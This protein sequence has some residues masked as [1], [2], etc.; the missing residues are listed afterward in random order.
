MLFGYCMLQVFTQPV[1]QLMEARICKVIGRVSVPVMGRVLLRVV[2]VLLLTFVAILVSQF[3]SCKDSQDHNQ[4]PFAKIMYGLYTVQRLQ[5]LFHSN[6]CYA[7]HQTGND[8][9]HCQDG[10]GGLHLC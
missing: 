3:S 9:F 6:L 10:N 1:F 7:V 2:Y 5:C 4:G 8:C